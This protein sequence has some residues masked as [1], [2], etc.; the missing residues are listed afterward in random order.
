MSDTT[1]A[2]TNKRPTFLTVL[3]I[4]SFIAGGWGVIG[5]IINVVSAPSADEVRAQMEGALSGMGDLEG[6]EAF[7]GVMN[8]MAETAIKAAE[9]AVPMAIGSIVIALISLFGVWKMWNLQKQGFWIYVLACVASFILPMVFLGGGL[10]GAL[11]A[12]IGGL[13]SIVFIILYALNLKHMH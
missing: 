5:G 3:C 13:I 11:S 1:S 8:S 7:S 4:L 2:G 10:L 9:N 12:G 6:G